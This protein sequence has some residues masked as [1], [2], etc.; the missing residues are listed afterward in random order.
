VF[1]A[2]KK[3]EGVLFWTGEQILEWYGASRPAAAQTRR[4]A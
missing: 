4:S 2:L 3:Q 1:R